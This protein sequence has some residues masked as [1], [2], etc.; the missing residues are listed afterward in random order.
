MTLDDKLERKLAAIFY[1]DVAGYSQLTGEDE[2][3]TH[4][5]L[6]T[7]LDIISSSIRSYAG[8]VVHYAGDAVLAEFPTVTAA[9]ACAV[10]VQAELQEQNE[11]LK[12]DRQVKFRIGVNLGEVIV[13]RNDIYGDGVNVAARLETLADPGGICIS[14]SVYTAVGK[15]LPL[16]FEDLGEQQVKNIE[17]PVRSFRVQLKQGAVLPASSEQEMPRHP[18]RHVVVAASTVTM[19]VIGAAA[20]YWAIPWSP[21][22]GSVRQESITT[23]RPDQLSISSPVPG[24][25]AIAVLPFANV[26]GD[27]QQEYFSDGITDDLMTDLSKIS[28]LMVIARNSVFVYKDKPVKV[29]QMAKELGVRYLLEGSVRRAGDRVRINAQLIDA[30]T[31]GH[32]WAERYDESLDDVFALQDKVTDSIVTALKVELTPQEKAFA[33]ST[34]TKNVEAY[35]AFLAGWAHLLRKTPEDAVKAIVLFDKALKLDPNYSR[36]YAAL[37]QIYWDYSNDTKFHRLVDAS[38][39]SNYRSLGPMIYVS[40]WNFLQKARRQFSAEA[41]TLTAHILQ[42]Q[43]R[44]DEA[45]R[46]A[47]QAVALGPNNPTAYDAL[48]E[49]LIYAGKAEEALKQIEQSIRLDPN[50]PGEKLFLK[51]MAYYTQGRLEEAVSVIDRARSHNPKQNRYAAIQAAA[52]AELGQTSEAKVAFNHYLSAWI[53]FAD[54]NWVMYYWPFQQLETIDRLAESFIKAGISAPLK[55]YYYSVVK[56]NR[57]TS[58]Q[59]KSLLSDKIMIGSDRSYYGISEG[60]FEVTRDHNIQIVRQDELNYFHIGEKTRIDND[61]LCDHWLDFDKEY[62][63]AIFRNPDGRQDERNEYFFYTLTGVFTFSVFDPGSK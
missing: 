10:Q 19:I 11:P 25:P 35:D 21:T 43:R 44:F 58:D 34:D 9:L 4:R 32:L 5:R 47:K 8:N 60:E 41:H 36:V 17:H 50:L 53:T 42:R 39:D 63:V 55:R 28:G 38:L 56:Q 61:L 33:T 18:K 26:S 2:E 14:E 6:S 62:C 16:D 12:L 57:L 48:I 51:G 30:N 23:Q 13:D 7:Y 20:L 49:N 29:Q 37:A 1:A 31:G 54:L 3:G 15:K 24:K 22:N 46:E 40:A 59:I 27:P 45:M 52:L